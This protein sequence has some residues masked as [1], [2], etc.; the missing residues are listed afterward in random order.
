MGFVG[1]KS[2]INSNSFLFAAFSGLLGLS[3]L[4]SG[5]VNQKSVVEQACDAYK[6]EDFDLAVSKFAELIRNNYEIEKY[7]DLRDDLALVSRFN[8]GEIDA[9]GWEDKG[10]FRYFMGSPIQA[11][12]R[13][14]YFCT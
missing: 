9:E 4:L 13:L 11:K 12:N 6:N 1:K 2:V 14:D 3:I 10:S 7:R 5:C 8:Q